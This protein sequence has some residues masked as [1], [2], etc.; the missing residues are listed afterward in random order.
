MD[1]YDATKCYFASKNKMIL[2][3]TQDEMTKIGNCLFELI[4]T[5]N[6]SNDN[7]TT[8]LLMTRNSQYN[9]TNMTTHQLLEN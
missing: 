3:G 5:L 6:P 4:Q 1:K 7:K 8:Q 9:E 2:Q